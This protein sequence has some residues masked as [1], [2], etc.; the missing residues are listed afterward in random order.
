MRRRPCWVDLTNVYEI[1]QHFRDLAN[2]GPMLDID[3]M[4]E[5]SCFRRLLLKHGWAREYIISF[6]ERAYSRTIY[7][8]YLPHMQKEAGDWFEWLRNRSRWKR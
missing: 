8:Q 6:E 4:N 2:I 7:E 1:V 5:I 3:L